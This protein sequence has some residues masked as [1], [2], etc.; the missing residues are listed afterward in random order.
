MTF[1]RVARGVV[2]T[3]ALLGAATSCKRS[4]DSGAPVAK[5]ASRAEAGAP[6][7][8]SDAATPPTV[9]Q[10]VATVDAATAE[11]ATASQSADASTDAPAGEAAPSDTAGETADGAFTFLPCGEPPP[12]MACIPGGPFLR[13]SDDGESN[14]R[15][16][17]PGRWFPVTAIS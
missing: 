8:P 2:L 1:S 16:L 17:A 7:P 11:A 4:D 12:G 10:D 5:E 6:S 13:G 9:P 15:A 3:A 14:E